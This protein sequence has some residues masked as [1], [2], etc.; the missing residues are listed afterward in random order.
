MAKTREE[1]TPVREHFAAHVR[2]SITM[3][4]YVAICLLAALAVV[5][6]EEAEHQGTVLKLV[7]GTTVGL[8]LAHWLAFRMATRL[9]SSNRF[10]REDATAAGFQVA[11]ATAVAVAATIPV[12]LFDGERELTAT[13][14]VIAAVLALAGYLAARSGS[15][16][17][18]RS[19]L[20]GAGAFVAALGV[21]LVKN[22]FSGH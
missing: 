19:L 8:A 5:S 9:T 13:R 14:F 3:A 6:A 17:P 2:E 11:G 12:L 4:L 7:W 16:G 10:E 21:A 18:V 20:Y 22:A 15:A 1:T